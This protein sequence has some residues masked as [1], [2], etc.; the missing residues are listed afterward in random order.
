MRLFKCTVFLKTDNITRSYSSFFFFVVFLFSF[1]RLQLIY[2]C[3][4]QYVFLHL[5][6]SFR[7]LA[8]NLSKKC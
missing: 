5:Y 6:V 3:V 1:W 4:G 7:Q 2:I 8:M